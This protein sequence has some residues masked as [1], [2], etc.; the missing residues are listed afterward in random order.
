MSWNTWNEMWNLW[1]AFVVKSIGTASSYTLN[2]DNDI[3]LKQLDIFCRCHKT[4]CM[5][6]KKWSSLNSSCLLLK[7]EHEGDLFVLCLLSCS[8]SGTSTANMPWT[9]AVQPSAGC[10]CRSFSNWRYRFDTHMLT[11]THSH[12]H[13]IHTNHFH[14][15]PV[16]YI[17][18]KSYSLYYSFKR[19]LATLLSLVFPR[20]ETQTDMMMI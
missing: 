5:S 18:N 3:Y 12:T 13:S 7:I 15:T 19:E 11:H 9:T 17:E 4:S 14:I 16:S 10:R 1:T 2:S 8:L 20:N 6:G